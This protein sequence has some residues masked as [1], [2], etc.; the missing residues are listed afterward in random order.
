MLKSIFTYGTTLALTIATF[1]VLAQSGNSGSYE[2]ESKQ[3]STATGI[4]LQQAVNQ[5]LA[6]K[7]GHIMEAEREREDGQT[8]FEIKG[9]DAEGARYKVYLN[10]ANGEILQSHGDD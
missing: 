3:T 4:S 2:E 10:A 6:E 7:G 5:V 9:V 8:L 1:T